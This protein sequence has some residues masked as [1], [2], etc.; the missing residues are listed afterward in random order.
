LVRRAKK[1]SHAQVD[2][3]KVIKYLGLDAGVPAPNEQEQE[4]PKE[5]AD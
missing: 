3:W 2:F 1:N 5:L 4:H